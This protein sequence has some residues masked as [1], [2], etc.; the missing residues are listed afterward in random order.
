LGTGA[1]KV[2]GQVTS[3]PEV[4]DSEKVDPFSGPGYAAGQMDFV[5]SSDD[6]LHALLY[7]L[8]MGPTQAR[9][10]ELDGD[11][12]LLRTA[13]LSQAMLLVRKPLDPDQS[14]VL[15]SQILGLRD[16]RLEVLLVG[17][18]N[19]DRKVLRDALPL[20]TGR[21]VRL[22]HLPDQGGLWQ[23]SSSAW[24]FAPRPSSRWPLAAYLATGAR[25]ATAPDWDAFRATLAA[26]EKSAEETSQQGEALAAQMAG[27]TPIATWVLAPTILA[28]FALQRALG[29]I[30][31]P[32]L[33]HMG[34]LYRPRVAD[35]ELWRLFSCAF[36]HG[37]IPHLA[38]NLVALLLFGMQLERMVGTAR[39]LLIYAASTLGGSVLSLVANRGFSVGASGALWGLMAAQFVFA[40]RSGRLL[41]RPVQRRMLTGAGQNLAINVVNSF[42]P[43]VDWA[44][45]AGGGLVGA[46]AMLLFLAG[47][48]HSERVEGS[49][50][51]APTSH[52]PTWLRP[53]A[54]A[55]GAIMLAGALLGPLLG[56]PWRLTE[57]PVF[58]RI[59]V[60]EAK[61]SIEVPRGLRTS[62]ASAQ[63]TDEAP[64]LMSGDAVA[65]GVLLDVRARPV[66]LQGL[67][68]ARAMD[69]I[70]SEV[71]KMPL[72]NGYTKAEDSTRRVVEGATLLERRFET[73]NGVKLTHLVRP[74]PTAI[75]ILDMV[76]LPGLSSAW[77]S[78]GEHALLSIEYRGP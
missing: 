25:G 78:V 5:P 49:S 8:V 71:N 7:D 2:G 4:G 76:E 11:A 44:A 68:M 64:E 38:F 15:R 73:A 61:Y 60:S 55:A 30:D 51:P 20:F 74:T 34:A 35:G 33:I 56:R 41:P 69:L 43:G 6:R 62:F 54:I 53:T 9:V 1:P 48:A 52:A 10:V 21:G 12:V 42:R 63:A 70:E 26:G 23:M 19:Q 14:I 50:T 75:L 22:M 45:H 31:S 77:H 16:S 36:L 67:G 3:V 32:G 24:P 59:V 17:G 29:A 47:M 46:A 66:S 65:D 13:D 40:W 37:N 72:P 39:Y 28:F 57:P 27:R 58:E 18:G